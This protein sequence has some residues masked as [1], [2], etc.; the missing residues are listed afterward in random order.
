MTKTGQSFWYKLDRLIAWTVFPTPISSAI[1]NQNKNLEFYFGT[2]NNVSKFLINSSISLFN[3]ILPF[4]QFLII[5]DLFWRIQSHAFYFLSSK[6]FKKYKLTIEGILE[7][8]D[9]KYLKI[10]Y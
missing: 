7:Q 8:I 2:I 5:Y 10:Y 6:N 3:C 9:D 4:I 1:N